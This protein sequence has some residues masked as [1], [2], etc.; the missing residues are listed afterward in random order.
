[1]FAPTASSRLRCR[2]RSDADGHRMGAYAVAR[3]AAG[4]VG[5]VEN[6]RLLNGERLGVILAVAHHES[7]RVDAS[8]R[9]APV[10]SADPSSP[11]SGVLQWRNSRPRRARSAIG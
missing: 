10:V 4:G 2:L 11:A 5:G 3:D 9:P 7:T 6:R 8:W 1:M